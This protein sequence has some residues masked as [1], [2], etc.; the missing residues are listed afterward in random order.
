[1]RERKPGAAAARAAEATTLPP[2]AATVASTAAWLREPVPAAPLQVFRSCWSCCLIKELLD[3]LPRLPSQ[4]G[5]GTFNFKYHFLSVDTPSLEAIHGIFALVL[6]A[7]VYLA[8]SPWLEPRWLPHWTG[9]GACVTVLCGYGYLFLLEVQRYN[10]HYYLSILL[11]AWLALAPLTAISSNKNAGGAGV[12]I[13]APRWQLEALRWQIAA[14]YFFGGIAK[15][16]DDWLSGA[17]WYSLGGSSEHGAAAE[18]IRQAAELLPSLGAPQEWQGERAA[19]QLL[20]WG[21]AAFD[22]LIGPLLL[23]PYRP[24]VWLGVLAASGFH[25]S[26]LLS[27]T[28]GIF[29]ITMVS[30]RKPT[31]FYRKPTFFYRKSMFLLLNPHDLLL[32]TPKIYY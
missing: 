16:S 29:P 32:R 13:V 7:L 26:N 9:R 8:A 14:V 10:N 2:A 25:V 5:P 23:A 15:L 4:Y 11:A 31:F 27:F 1:M 19:A 24:V 18:L 6:A 28:I 17:T 21:G 20:S 22:L 30:G 12:H 3:E